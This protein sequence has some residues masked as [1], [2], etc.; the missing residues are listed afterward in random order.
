MSYKERHDVAFAARFKNNNE[1]HA[2][3]TPVKSS[4]L[5]PGACGYFDYDGKWQTIIHL[6]DQT[7]LEAGNWPPAPDIA[8]K[9]D[10]LKENWGAMISRNDFEVNLKAAGGVSVPTAPVGGTLKA[11]YT[12]KSSSGAIL[13]AEGSVTHNELTPTACDSAKAWFVNSAERILKNK[14]K[15]IFNYI[16]RSMFE[17]RGIEEE[18]GIWVVT[19]TY[20]A[21]RRAVALLQTR[22]SSVSFGLDLGLHGA[23]I[24]APEAAWWTSNKEQVW[25]IAPET[26]QDGSI[27]LFMSGWYWRPSMFSRKPDPTAKKP[28]QK[29]FLGGPEADK[30]L[31]FVLPVDDDEEQEITL[32]LE[33]IGNFEVS[34]ANEEHGHG[35]TDSD[36]SESE[37]E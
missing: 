11:E 5:R 13:V 16:W 3:Y 9:P 32:S 19:K 15:G 4:D 31:T 7:A 14:D 26:A 36:A 29:R 28:D 2:L 22:E 24:Q 10:P 6:T 33:Q 25:K 21:S 30:P 35:D 18:K 23:G 20:T 8:L 37:E 27:P 1:G 17:K 34:D 12:L